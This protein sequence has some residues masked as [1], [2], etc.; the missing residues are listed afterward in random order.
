MKNEIIM[1]IQ[2]DDVSS[3]GS[4]PRQWKYGDHLFA[5]SLAQNLRTKHIIFWLLFAKALPV[6]YA[7]ESLNVGRP[8]FIM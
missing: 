4:K 2:E 7:Q 6:L 8:S 5:A 1:A 3:E